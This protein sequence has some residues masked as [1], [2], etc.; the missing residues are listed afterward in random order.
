MAGTL[1]ITGNEQGLLSGGKTIGPNTYTGSATVGQVT[2]VTL[3]TGDNTLTV[4]TGASY[5]YIVVSSGN[6]AVLKVRT[7]ANSADAGLSLGTQG[8]GV[9]PLPT[10]VTSVIVNAASG[11]GTIEA[12]FI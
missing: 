12:T 2:D 1:T 9:F 10:G 8:P 3:T 6:T 5:V 11:G 4:P 7:S